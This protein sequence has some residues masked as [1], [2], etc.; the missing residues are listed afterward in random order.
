MT[1]QSNKVVLIANHFRWHNISK[2]D[3]SQIP[4]VCLVSFYFYISQDNAN[5][6]LFLRNP[7]ILKLHSAKDKTECLAINN[8]FISRFKTRS[9]NNFYQ[10]QYFLLFVFQSPCAR[11]LLLFT[12]FREFRDLNLDCFSNTNTNYVKV[13]AKQINKLD[14]IWVENRE[15]IFEIKNIEIICQSK[16]PIIFNKYSAKSWQTRLS[17]SQKTSKLYFYFYKFHYSTRYGE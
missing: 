2:I 17:I 6:F 15:V 10:F 5:I 7:S 3:F 4:K 11:I 8:L 13:R 16:L 1:I 9:L 14:I 12:F